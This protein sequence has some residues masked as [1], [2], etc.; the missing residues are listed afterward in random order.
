MFVPPTFD[1]SCNIWRNASLLTAPPDLV[2]PC[3]LRLVKDSF[4]GV[5]GVNA[6]TMLLCLPKGTDVRPQGSTSFHD[7]I[8]APAGTGRF[9]NCL[10]VDDVGK[11]FPNEYRVALIQPVYSLWTLPIA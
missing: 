7:Q 1:L 5:G 11:G 8:E 9:Y 6:G 2:S 10:A 3:Q 4:A